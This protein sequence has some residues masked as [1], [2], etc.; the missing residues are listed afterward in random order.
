M[1]HVDAEGS[2]F[3]EHVFQI[4]QV[5]RSIARMMRRTPGIEPPGIK[6]AAHQRPLRQD[7]T[8]R[9]ET[10][11]RIGAEIGHLEQIAPV[12]VLKLLDWVAGK[13]R[14][15]EPSM[16]ERLAQIAHILGVLS[17]E[18]IFVLDLNHKDRAAAGDLQRRQHS[19]HFH[20][21][22]PRSL[23]VARVA[24]AQ[25]DVL[26]LEQPPGKTAHFPFGARIRSGTQDDPQAL[27]LGDTAELCDVS[28]ALPIELVGIRLVQIPE[29][30]SANRVQ[31][32]RPRHS[33][34]VLP[35]FARHARGVD[36]PATNLE[37]AAIQQEIIR[38]DGEGVPGGRGRGA[39]GKGEEDAERGAR[40]SRSA[41]FQSAAPRISNLQRV[42][43]YRNPRRTGC[44][45]EWNSAIQ[46]IANLRQ[47]SPRGEERL[48]H[49]EESFWVYR[50]VH[51]RALKIE[52]R[53][54]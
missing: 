39:E 22:A 45:V 35:V 12:T 9:L 19:S 15:I 1:N 13:Q 18:S 47:T 44:R 5:T 53:K 24:S 7:L 40:I 28:L 29:K 54:L 49:S 42:R 32:H 16:D 46:Q 33:Q 43:D 34:S 11:R 14:N 8:Q 48:P 50:Q 41:D 4:A 21:I 27:L 38:T 20:E 23:D 6:L 26:V 30:I 10:A 37:T 51:R 25:L 52:N 2:T 31:P 3:I 36:F 17:I